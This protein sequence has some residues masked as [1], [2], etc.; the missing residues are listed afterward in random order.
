MNQLT[1]QQ[2]TWDL[3]W[4]NENQEIRVLV[5]LGNRLNLNVSFTF[6]DEKLR[7]ENASPCL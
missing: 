6:L 2:K 3:G 7:E 5:V 4:K 1:H